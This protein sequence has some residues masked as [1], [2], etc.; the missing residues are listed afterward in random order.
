M[1]RDYTKAVEYLKTF[2]GVKFDT[3]VVDAFLE[4]TAVYPAGS[5]VYLSDGS[6]GRVIR[7]NKK[8][9]DRP[10]IQI[11][12]DSNGNVMTKETLVDLIKINHIFVEKVLE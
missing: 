12:K 7:Q 2:R 6:V 10:V 4:F 11:L 9:P 3:K 5:Q 8:F 1:E